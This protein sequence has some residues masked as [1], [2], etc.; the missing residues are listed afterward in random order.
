MEFPFGLGGKSWDQA[1]C[2]SSN[3]RGDD[4][5][6]WVWH[7]LHGAGDSSAT[8]GA[9]RL[10]HRAPW[11]GHDS[12]GH[13][14]CSKNLLVVPWEGF[15]R[16]P[17]WVPCKCPLPLGGTEPPWRTSSN[18]KDNPSILA[19][20]KKIINKKNTIKK[21]KQTQTNNSLLPMFLHWT[22]NKIPLS[23]EVLIHQWEPNRDLHLWMSQSTYHLSMHTVLFVFIGSVGK[24]VYSPCLVNENWGGGVDKL[25]VGGIFV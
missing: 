3:D 16:V 11:F 6:Q 12:L 13:L 10:P 4:G 21:E 20:N 2:C 19:Q 5:A 8:P 24:I 18:Q 7:L 9:P 23:S 22:K 17:P 15:W 25:W 1:R 14:L